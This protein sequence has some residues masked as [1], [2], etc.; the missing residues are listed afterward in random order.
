MLSDRAVLSCPRVSR[1]YDAL[2]AARDPF[3]RMWR[4]GNV[5]DEHL[6][7]ARKAVQA[8]LKLL[9]N[10]RYYHIAYPALADLRRAEDSKDPAERKA[11]A[12]SAE[13]HIGVALGELNAAEG[14]A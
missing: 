3:R 7:T 10:T 6:R 1:A 9:G 2:R 12:E 14:R 4:D 11:Y 8:A 5:T 13:A